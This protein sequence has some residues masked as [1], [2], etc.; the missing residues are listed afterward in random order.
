MSK[1]LL[2]KCYKND[3]CKALWELRQGSDSAF[4]GISYQTSKVSC[5]GGLELGFKGKIGI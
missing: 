4:W 1:L 2:G 3:A 5:G